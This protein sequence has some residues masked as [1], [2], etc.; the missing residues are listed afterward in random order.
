MLRALEYEGA[1]VRP[2]RVIRLYPDYPPI[3]RGL[4]AAIGQLGRTAEAKEVL[5]KA[6]A[7]APTA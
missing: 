3:Y 7:I 5:D 4:A 1:I 2:R 6:I